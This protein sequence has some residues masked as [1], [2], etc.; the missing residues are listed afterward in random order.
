MWPLP[1]L[2]QLILSLFVKKA[3]HTAPFL[4]LC[5]GVFYFRLAFF[6]DC[7]YTPARPAIIRLRLLGSGMLTVG[8]PAVIHAHVLLTLQKYS[9][10]EPSARVTSAGQSLR[11]LQ[12]RAK[13]GSEIH[14]AITVM[15]VEKNRAL[16]LK[17][18]VFIID[19]LA[20]WSSVCVST[21]S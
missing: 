17:K 1:G 5:Y 19:L 16:L 13:A 15:A 6:L 3:P 21:K 4:L 11:E 7:R 9:V 12:E 10:R 20:M 2:R 8:T 18:C 14:I